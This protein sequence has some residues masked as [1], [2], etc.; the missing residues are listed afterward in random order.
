MSKETKSKKDGTPT[1]AIN[2]TLG[3]V[4]QL[5]NYHEEMQTVYP[6]QDFSKMTPA[7]MTVGEWVSTHQTRRRELEELKSSVWGV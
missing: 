6:P 1:V 4:L 5:I 7:K 2:I 3:E